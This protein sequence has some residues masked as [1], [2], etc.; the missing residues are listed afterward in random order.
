MPKVAKVRSRIALIATLAV[1]ASLFVAL[2]ASAATGDVEKPATF[3]ACVGAATADAGFGDTAGSFADASIDCIAHYKVTL[4]TAPGVYSPGAVVTREQ[5]ALFL[6]RAAGP[7]GI[8]VPAAA[9]QGF[10]DI[11]NL[12][13]ASQDAINQLAALG[14]SKGTSTTTYSPADSVSRYQ[15]ALFLVRFLAK[16]GVTFDGTSGSGFTDTG[17]VSFEAYNAIEDAYDLGVTT[18]TTKTTFSPFAAVTREQMAAFIARTLGHTNARPAGISFQASDTAITEGDDVDVQISVR[19]ASHKPVVDALVDVFYTALKNKATALKTDG[20]CDTAVVNPQF[21]GTECTIELAEATA[22]NSKGN[23]DATLTEGA[24]FTDSIIWWAWTGNAGA[25]FD[26]DTTEVA[27]VEVTVSLAATDWLLTDNVSDDAY[28]HWSSFNSADDGTAVK[29]GSTATIT[30]QLVDSNE[31]PVAKSGEKVT[32][33]VNRY[34]NGSF[35][36][37]TVTQYSSD[38]SGKV[39]VSW[40]ESDTNTGTWVSGSATDN[41]VEIDWS[42]SGTGLGVIDDTDNAH[43]TYEFDDDPSEA[44]DIFGDHDAD[45]GLASDA[46][47]GA[48]HTVRGTVVD[49]YGAGMA[50]QIVSFTSNDAAGIGATAINRT[51]NSSGVATLSYN[52]DL[53]SAGIEAITVSNVDAGSDGMTHYWVL[54]APD[55]YDNVGTAVVVADA[56]NDAIV[57]IDGTPWV[58]YYDSNDQFKVDGAAASFENFDKE[59]AKTLAGDD[60]V[61]TDYREAPANISQ[62]GWLN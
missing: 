23:I 48:T 14:V 12:P 60:I 57:F 58:V 11:A 50:G 41:V 25:T 1:V 19:D 51:T 59:V 16:A 52:R 18:G 21:G 6:I 9:S 47:T 10:T 20:T 39:T 35:A 28:D 55:G 43:Q 34:V 54:E 8:T 44:Y 29:F 13:Q 46:G 27:A 4:G 7:A 45:Y 3:S 33:T 56:V 30:L 17:S 31:D 5:M 61:I 32:I 37:T 40:T 62:L 2:P 22:T 42:Y 38:A 24:D 53:A 36:G 15:M 26:V 49:Q